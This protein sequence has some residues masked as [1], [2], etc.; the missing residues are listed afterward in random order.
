MRIAPRLFSVA[1]ALSPTLLGCAAPPPLSPDASAP[2]ANAPDASSPDAHAP[3]AHAPDANAPDASAPDVGE[4]PRVPCLGGCPAG[5]QCF[6][7]G[8]LPVLPVGARCGLPAVPPARYPL[9]CA[10]D[11]TCVARADGSV[12]VARGGAGAWCRDASPRCDPGLGCEDGTPGVCRPA[13]REGDFCLRGTTLCVDGTHC[14]EVRGVPRCVRDGGPGGGC[15]AAVRTPDGEDTSAVCDPG[16]RCT[17]AEAMWGWWNSCARPGAEGDPCGAP[18][19]TCASGLSCVA[20]TGRCARNGTLGAQCVSAPGARC[21]ADGLCC[22]EGLACEGFTPGASVCVRP[23]AEGGPCGGGVATRCAPGTA[24]SAEGPWET[25]RCV[26]PGSAPGADCRRE[27]AACDGALRC[28]DFSRYRSTCREEVPAGG[29]CDLG[30]VATRCPEGQWCLA[31]GEAPEGGLEARCAPPVREQEPN[32]DLT[33]RG[34]APTASTVYAGELSGRDARD[35]AFVRVGTGASLWLELQ[36]PSPSDGLTRLHVFDPGGVE[37]ARWL[38][39][40]PGNH[41]PLG[42]VAR[43]TPDRATVLRGVAGGVWA[44]CVSR[45]DASQALRYTLAVSVLGASR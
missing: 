12:C 43:F 28:S 39:T 40:G 23:V 13:V 21:N 3:D 1:L 29:R 27:G 44:V 14:R 17:V 45:A 32:D 33:P 18:H 16:L 6:S 30:R 42:D 41:G 36:G 20:A 19:A 34:E 22:D 24:C 5:M 7:V 37:V 4:A 26:A 35:C 38:P 10:A 15:R 11:S 2:D 31:T 25:G 8:C 9:Q